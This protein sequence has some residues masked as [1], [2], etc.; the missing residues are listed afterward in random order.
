MI[1]SKGHCISEFIY[2]FLLASFIIRSHRRLLRLKHSKL[3][4]ILIWIYY[5]ASGDEY[6]AEWF[7]FLWITSYSKA[8]SSIHWECQNS[9]MISRYYNSSITTTTIT[10]LCVKQVANRMDGIVRFCRDLNRWNYTPTITFSIAKKQV[11]NSKYCCRLSD[12]HSNELVIWILSGNHSNS[13]VSYSNS[14]FLSFHSRWKRC[15]ALSDLNSLDFILS[16]ACWD[17]EEQK[18]L[19]T[20]RLPSLIRT[21]KGNSIDLVL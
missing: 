10:S 11:F 3:F 19:Q 9:V 6:S 8:F 16:D 1:D 13:I 12:L 17:S 18:H 2:P 4:R 5:F 21:L 20:Q 14:L 15:R 7:D